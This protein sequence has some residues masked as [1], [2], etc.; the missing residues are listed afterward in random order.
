MITKMTLLFMLSVFFFAGI[1][2]QNVSGV[3]LYRDTINPV[4]CDTITLG[5]DST[6]VLIAS[7]FPH[8]AA[9][10]SVLWSTTNKLIVDTVSVANDTICKIRGVD[11]GQGK[12]VV[13]T[14]DAHRTDTCVVNVIIPMDSVTLRDDSMRVRLGH[15]TVLIA[16]IYPFEPR[17][18]TNSEIRWTSSDPSV[19]TVS[20]TDEDTVCIIKPKEI[21]VATIYVSSV[22]GIRKDSCV[23]TVE[24]LPVADLVLSHDSIKELSL[25]NDT[26]L[27]ARVYPLGETNDSV[28]WSSNNYSIVDIISQGYDT[29]CRIRGT[30][31]G[32]TYIFAYSVDNTRKD[33]CYVSV[34]PIPADGISLNTD[35]L[36]LMIGADTTLTATI[37]PSNVTNDSVLWTSSDS[38]VIDIITDIP[39]K[40]GT[41]CTI[42]AKTRKSEGAYIYAQTFD[43]GFKDSCYVTVIVPLDSIVLDS[44]TMRMNLKNDTLRVL[45]ARIHPD[46]ATYDSLKWVNKAER[47]VRID[48]IVNDTLC[49]I[50]ALAPGIDTLCVVA[51]GKSDTCY[52]TIDPCL[53]DSV[54]I[55]KDNVRIV[56]TLRLD[57]NNEVKLQIKAYPPNATEDSIN[58]TSSA[59]G[60]LRIDSLPDGVYIHALEGGTAVVRARAVDGS[61]QKDSCIVKITR[62][63][64]TGIRLNKDTVYTFVDKTDSVIATVSPPNAADKTI[65]WRTFD[66]V[67]NNVFTDAIVKEPSTNDSIYTFT[68]VHADTIL[69]YAYAVGQESGIKDSSVVIVR[70]RFI[71]ADTMPGGLIEVSLV[72]PDAVTVTGFFRLHLPKGFGLTWEGSGDNRKY[73]SKLTEGYAASYDLEITRQ[74]DSTY[75]FNI[76][77][78]TTSTSTM[79]RAGLEKKVL[80]IY[81][82]I[83][84]NALVNSTA[85]YNVRLADIGFHFGNEPELRE[86]QLYIKIKVYQD[87]T[88]NELVE[89]EGVIAYAEDNRLYVNTAKAETVHVYSSDGSLILVKDKAEGAILFDLNTENKI[90]FIRGSSGWTRKVVNL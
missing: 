43:G 59:P 67:T 6:E 70:D 25:G 83:Y 68:A 37:S 28:K 48:S 23:V 18:P 45:I 77:P 62:V 57:V 76:D 54:R 7:V 87:P 49:Y 2:A 90:L 14:K 13:K 42:Q 10:K 20:V 47:L 74:N 17:T 26:T 75:S 50:K 85:T 31:V 35:S 44:L 79:L 63:P 16:K 89:K 61:G 53:V 81:Y 84:D 1:K 80:N 30:G 9:D 15:D 60:I 73:K 64:T 51:D 78:K 32:G 3:T 4:S 82:T 52:I 72:I 19:I 40:N 71:Y 55:M 33:S 46:S 21:G 41:A 22:D 66:P 39:V 11:V 65:V 5:V 12:I 24:A 34:L 88:G 56:D 27:I 86:D 8:D 36:D 29:I 69:I 38:T 58:V